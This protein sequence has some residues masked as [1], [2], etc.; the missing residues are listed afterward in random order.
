MAQECWPLKVLQVSSAV[1]ST[2]FSV[3]LALQCARTY[4]TRNIRRTLSTLEM[5][6]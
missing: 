2:A 4:T 6:C 5:S 1:P 3:Y